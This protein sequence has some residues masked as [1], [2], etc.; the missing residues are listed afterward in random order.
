MN[1]NFPCYEKNTTG[2]KRQS[3][4]ENP[5]GNRSPFTVNAGCE[6]VRQAIPGVKRAKLSLGN[7][8]NC[9][10]NQFHY[11]VAVMDWGGRS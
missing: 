1:M 10:S 9:G 2:T 6:A 3:S 7:E 4:Q 11:D 8:N 5:P